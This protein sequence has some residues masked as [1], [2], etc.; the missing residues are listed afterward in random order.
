MQS[1]PQAPQ[2]FGSPVVSM[3]VPPQSACPP[4]HTQLL[5]EQAL[6]GA[7]H[8]L[9]QPPQFIAS[10]LVSVQAVAQTV[11]PSGQSHALVTHETPAGHVFPHPP[12]LAASLVVSTQE[13]AHVLAGALQ[14][15][16]PFLQTWPVTVP[17]AIPSFVATRP[18][19]PP[20][21]AAVSHASPGGQSDGI[22]HGFPVVPPPPPS[23]GQGITSPVIGSVHRSFPSVPGL[24]PKIC[25]HPIPATTATVPTPIHRAPANLV[26]FMASPHPAEQE[27]RRSDPCQR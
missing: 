8:V 24:S 16:R 20:V 4:G 1:C 7:V 17:H 6:S 26:V 2:F 21:H 23:S 19:V 25:R 12:Q 9:P 14:V 18:H 5:P 13:P 10:V 11:P 22:S 27:P 3:Q 15:H